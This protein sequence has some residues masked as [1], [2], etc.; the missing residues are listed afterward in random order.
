MYLDTFS[1]PLTETECEIGFRPL[2]QKQRWDGTCYLG[3]INLY[4]NESLKAYD[5]QIE[6]EIDVG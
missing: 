3:Q 5:I 4:R 6:F 1:A 2:R